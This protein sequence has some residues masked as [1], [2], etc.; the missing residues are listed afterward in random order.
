M[1]TKTAAVHIEGDFFVP[2][3]PSE[4]EFNALCQRQLGAPVQGVGLATH[5]GSPGVA[6]RLSAST[7]VFLTSEGSADLSTA[8]AHAPK[9]R[10]GILERG[11]EVGLG[12]HAQDRFRVLSGGAGRR[13]WRGCNDAPQQ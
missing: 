3:Q 12:F 9:E 1:W 5:V 2:S 4:I 10:R 8:G 6:A 11:D 13:E 7:R